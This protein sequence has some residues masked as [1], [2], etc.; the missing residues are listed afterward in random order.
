MALDENGA[1]L[2]LRVETTCNMGA[3]LTGSWAMIPTFS[4]LGGLAG[5]YGTRDIPEQV[6][7]QIDSVFDG[8]ESPG[9]RQLTETAAS[10][11]G[12][13]AGDT[14]RTADLLLGT[15]ELDAFGTDAVETLD[16]SFDDY[17]SDAV[18]TSQD[19]T[20][21][22]TGIEYL[23]H[24]EGEKHL[25]FI[26]EKGLFLPRLENDTSLAA[27]ANDARVVIDTIHTGG[28]QPPRAGRGGG[29]GRG[30]RRAGPR[31]PGLSWEERFA[32]N[33]LRTVS[34]LTGGQ[35]TAFT[36]ASTGANRIA[37]ATSFQYLLGYYPTNDNWDGRYRAV[38]V[39]VNRPGVT[40]LYRHGY[41]GSQELPALDRQELLTYSR[42]SAAG[43]YDKPVTDIEIGLEATL[44]EGASEVVLE[45]TIDPSRLGLV[46]TGGRHVGALNLAILVGDSRESLV[47]ELWQTIDLNLRD[48]TYRS[49]LD[50]GIPHSARIPVSGQP[51]H[52]KVIVY[53]A[54]ADLV[55]SM[56]ARLR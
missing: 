4:N 10:D 44:N 12:R 26:T 39:R 52:V 3:Y 1:F 31:L 55:G 45:L 35:S 21:L 40:V 42:I 29:G 37:D 15:S 18:Q 48:A 7:D 8:P 54:A 25:V 47:G 30:G 53:D 16:I 32:V 27:V 51:E 20:N 43:N 41:Y 28:L 33:T 11:A 36:A 34:R 14:R 2:A 5:V 50:T 22:Y 46:E 6:Q 56:T 24:I 17:V 38:N 19:L 49:Y 23:R 9:M 13:I